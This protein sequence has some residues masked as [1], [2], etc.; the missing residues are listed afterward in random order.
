MSKRQYTRGVQPA[1]FRIST[2]VGW[3]SLAISVDNEVLNASP[4]VSLTTIS[5]DEAYYEWSDFRGVEV[6]LRVVRLSDQQGV[7]DEFDRRVYADAVWGALATFNP[8][9]D[10]QQFDFTASLAPPERGWWATGE[11]LAALQFTTGA[12]EVLVGGSDVDFCEVDTTLF[13]GGPHQWQPTEVS[14]FMSQSPGQRDTWPIRPHGSLSICA[15]RHSS[16][17]HVAR[18][19]AHL[20]CHGTFVGAQRA[21]PQYAPVSRQL[22][23]LSRRVL[24]C[25]AAALCRK[26]GFASLR[27]CAYGSPAA[28]QRSAHGEQGHKRH[29]AP[30]HSNYRK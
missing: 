30:L 27:G 3:V 12:T 2:P 8:A 14:T 9:C 5:C 26:R 1:L 19:I 17:V 10:G 7:A 24:A 13:L 28:T 21:C 16:E 11:D 20:S 4:D 15:V 18:L 22:R 6:T 25:C 23:R 29:W